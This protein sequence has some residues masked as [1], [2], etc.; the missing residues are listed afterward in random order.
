MN[1]D[2]GCGPVVRKPEHLYVAQTAS[3][4]CLGIPLPFCSG[5]VIFATDAF[6]A[7]L[8]YKFVNRNLTWPRASPPVSPLVVILTFDTHLVVHLLTLA[9]D[10]LTILEGR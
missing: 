1:D 7:A 9:D 8:I 3:P 2:V 10:H 4:M 5:H 6:F